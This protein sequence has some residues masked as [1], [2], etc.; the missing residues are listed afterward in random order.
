MAAQ[1]GVLFERGD[2]GATR[3]RTFDPAADTGLTPAELIARGW[4]G[5]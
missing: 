3:V 5:A 4:E 2:D 1:G